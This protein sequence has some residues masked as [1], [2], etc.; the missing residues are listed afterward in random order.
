MQDRYRY[1]VWD[2][3][4]K[5]FLSFV[6]F[7]RYSEPEF[8]YCSETKELWI[9]FNTD[10]YTIQQ[11]TGLYDKNGTLIYEGDLIRYKID[12][13]EPEWEY[14]EIVWG[15]N[16]HY[17]AFDLKVHEFDCNGLAYIFNE[18]WII[19]VIN[20]IYEAKNIIDECTKNC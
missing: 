4:K 13:V 17:P 3:L 10:R 8:N 15:G 6:T 2:K 7:R 11:C 14:T 20:N 1:R 5:E 12:E 16:E 19:E 18:G 9:K